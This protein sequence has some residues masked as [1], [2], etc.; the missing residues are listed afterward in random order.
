M[1]NI[2]HVLTTVGKTDRILKINCRCSASLSKRWILWPVFNEQKRH[3]SVNAVKFKSSFC[4]SDWFVNISS[5]IILHSVLDNNYFLLNYHTAW[6]MLH[7]VTQVFKII[8]YFCYH[9]YNLFLFINF[10]FNI[11]NWRHFLNI[12]FDNYSEIKYLF[13]FFP[14]F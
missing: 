7:P 9:F 11:S 2:N 1:N 13:T 10:P 8:I 6:N 12:L 3:K 5:V 14:N 4:K